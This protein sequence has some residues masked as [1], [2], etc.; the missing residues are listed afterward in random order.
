MTFFSFLRYIPLNTYRERALV[1]SV[2]KPKLTFLNLYIHMRFDILSRRCLS[3]KRAFLGNSHSLQWESWSRNLPKMVSMLD[4]HENQI[5]FTWW[6]VNNYWS[7]K[8]APKMCKH[9]VD[10]N[11]LITALFVLNVVSRCYHEVK[12]FSFDKTKDKS[13][14]W[15]YSNFSLC[16]SKCVCCV[17]GTA[18]QVAYD[19]GNYFFLIIPVVCFA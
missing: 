11:N 2:Q 16:V 4:S 3:I 7:H 13:V 8:N 18:T 6:L 12:I 15:F 14:F 9:F 17:A 1:L 19:F 5:L 10:V